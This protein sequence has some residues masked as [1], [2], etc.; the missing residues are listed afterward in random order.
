MWQL[1]AFWTESNAEDKQ[2]K[3]KEW[4]SWEREKRKTH[5]KTLDLEITE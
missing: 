2:E 5:V 4:K 3:E 1:K